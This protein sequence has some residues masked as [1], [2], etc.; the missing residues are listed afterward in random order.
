M[1]CALLAMRGIQAQQL[2]SAEIQAI[3]QKA[4]DFAYPL[5]L[6]ELTR[7][8]TVRYA[9]LGDAQTNRFTQ[10]REFPDDKFRQVIRPNADTLYSS[11]WLDLSKEPIV[12]HAGDTG[13][14]YYMM[15]LMDAWTETISV[16]GKR[17]TGTG[18]NWFA[19]AGPGWKGELPARVHR[20]DCPTNVAW[21]LGRTQT[22][23][24]SDYPLV[25]K[26]QDGYVL[27][28]LSRY[29]DGPAPLTK[30][31][32]QPDT[33]G[34]VRPPQEVERMSA[35]EFFT[36][37]AG[38][39]VENPPHAGDGPMMAEI[40]KIGVVA[41]KFDPSALGTDGMK[42]IEQGAAAA[43]AHLNSLTG[44]VGEPG[45]TGWTGWSK[46]VGRYG[47]HYQARAEVARIGLGAN[48]P[49]DAV[50]LHCRQDANGHALDGAHR[51][52]MH[53]AKN[54]IPR[55]KAFWSVTVYSEDGYFTANALHRY[56][57]GDRDPLKFNPDGSLD[58]YIQRESPGAEKESNWLPAPAGAFNLSF[59]L[60]WAS[61][62]ILDGRWRPP[63]VANEP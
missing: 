34:F 24:V 15:Q 41:G 49:E 53:F 1:A 57:I 13:G 59:R 7:R 18:D 61:Q 43:A 26:L 50:Y 46:L 63:A 10:L 3:A 62:A 16:P 54:E 35:R 40:R 9:P 39:L 5:V 56:A 20:I 28:P 58:L 17:T 44:A 29:P 27:M 11:A 19:I 30:P 25:H 37:F 22:N 4:Y 60:Y 52:R 6:M 23:G 55:V 8:N 38:L 48:P 47:T 42:S 31:P 12:L 36:L 21:L 33:R 14:R 45:P 2:P 32:S 51:Y